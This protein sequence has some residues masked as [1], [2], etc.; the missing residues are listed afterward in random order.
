MYPVSEAY[1][2]ISKHD[3]A[4]DEDE[5]EGLSLRERMEERGCMYICARKEGQVE[6]VSR[7]FQG[8]V[9]VSPPP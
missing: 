6:Q 8:Q 4:Q 7:C 5:M 3:L 9:A 2:D 1:Q